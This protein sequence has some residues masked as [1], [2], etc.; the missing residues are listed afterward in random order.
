[1]KKEKNILEEIEEIETLKILKNTNTVI[2]LGGGTTINNKIKKE[3][4]N[5]HISFLVELNVK[6]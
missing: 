2:S 3:V 5:N 6:H 1:M 4:L